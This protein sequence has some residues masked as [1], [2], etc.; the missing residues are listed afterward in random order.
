M[1]QHLVGRT[2]EVEVKEYIENMLERY[3]KEFGQGKEGEMEEMEREARELR[4]KLS[5]YEENW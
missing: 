5:Y 1:K 2:D 3:S 4:R